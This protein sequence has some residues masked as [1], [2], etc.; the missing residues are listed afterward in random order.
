MDKLETYDHNRRFFFRFFLLLV[1]FF[2]LQYTLSVY[3][4][5][6]TTEA[7]LIDLFA[8]RPFRLSAE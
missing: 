6:V 1:L 7:N 8:A 2:L 3:L 4:I 5:A